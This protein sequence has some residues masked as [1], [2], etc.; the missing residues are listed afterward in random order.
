MEDKNNRR[1]VR[2]AAVVGIIVIWV[3]MCI[4][5]FRFNVEIMKMW[6]ISGWLYYVA[7]WIVVATPLTMVFFLLFDMVMFLLEDLKRYNVAVSDYLSHDCISDAFYSSL[8]VDAELYG[9]VLAGIIVL[10]C[11]V[12][13]AIK[14]PGD[15]KLLFLVAIAIVFVIAQVIG[16]KHPMK[17]WHIDGLKKVVPYLKKTGYLAMGSLL[18]VLF[19]S[20]MLL[21]TDCIVDVTFKDDGIVVIDCESSRLL[22]EIEV[23]VFD[24]HNDAVEIKTDSNNVLIASANSYKEE[25]NPDGEMIA[26]SVFLEKVKEYSMQMVDLSHGLV[27]D[28]VYTLVIRAVIDDRSVEIYNELEKNGSQFEFCEYHLTQSL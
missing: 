27:D 1:S 8:I 24:Q 5:L 13:S 9:I 6:P 16:K 23:N 3:T 17:Y 26:K 25:R 11:F 20:V 22:P 18:L 7:V 15:S 2:L 10:D 21:R 14:S 28:G 12:L 19:I 4:S